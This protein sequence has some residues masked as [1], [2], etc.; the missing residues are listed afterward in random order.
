MTGQMKHGFVCRRGGQVCQS[1][2]F[3]VGV[4]LLDDGAGGVGF[5]RGNRVGEGLGEQ[6]MDL[7]GVEQDRRPGVFFPVYLPDP[8]H[9]MPT[10]D[11]TRF[12]PSAELDGEGR[13]TSTTES[14]VLVV[15]SR[16]AAV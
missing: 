3:Q 15:W 14:H 7:V 2:V 11:A 1:A 8:E 13:A 12:L 10:L 9:D 5:I 4:D 6:L 16:I